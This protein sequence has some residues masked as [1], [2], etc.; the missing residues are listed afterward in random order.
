MT[1]TEVEKDVYVSGFAAFEQS[2]AVRN[3][4]WLRPLRTAAI[5]RFAELGFPDTR[6]ERWRHTNVAPIAKVPFTLA[7]RQ[8]GGLKPADLAPYVFGE[9][10][11]AQLV[12]VNGYFSDELSSL[13]SLPRG[14]RVKSMAAALESDR[15][16]IEPYLGRGAA[17]DHDPFAALN[18]AFMAD[19]VFIHIAPAIVL[20]Q[21]LHVLF[22]S[23]G[24]REPTVS[25]PRNL[26]VVGNG[27]QAAIIES[28]VALDRCLYLTNG[29][30]EVFLGNDAKVDFYKLQRESE[31]AFHIDTLN[32]T[33]ERDS[34][35][36]SHSISIGGAIVRNN[37]DVRLDG[38]GADCILNGLYVTKGRQHVDNH[39]TVDHARSNCGSRE[40]YKGIL[41]DRSTGVF[42]G[43]I[44]VRKDAQKTNAKQSNRNLLLSRDALVNTKPEL[45]IFADDVK[46][47]HGA[48]IGQLDEE[49]LFYLRSRGLDQ[50]SARVLLTYA[51]ANDLLASMK[52]K[53]MQC[54]LDLVLLTRLSRGH[55]G[56]IDVGRAPAGIEGVL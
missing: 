25:H 40:L 38:Q 22:L 30:T 42:H 39:T 8:A 23:T 12:F 4:P 6:N 20:K 49:A 28:Y 33:Q 34:A 5:S 27:S 31:D 35:F 14:V 32:V 10:D 26:I 41:D 36:S 1:H 21:P 43:R 48:T 7:T 53:P 17:L 3:Q 56:P 50:D 47:T 24:R 52:I 15:R 54:Q 37:I 44:V 19:G 29:L 55:G 51:F 2:A 16:L 13:A 11:W 9:P 46:C 45:E 18:T